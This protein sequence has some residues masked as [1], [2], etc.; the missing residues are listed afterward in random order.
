MSAFDAFFFGMVNGRGWLYRFGYFCQLALDK[1]LLGAILF[2]AFD[3]LQV[4]LQEVGA[5]VP[6]KS[7]SQRRILS[8][9][10]LV[11]AHDVQEYPRHCLQQF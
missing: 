9:F 4:R 8:I 10:A 3:A 1:A 7:F 2:G 6:T 11:I 5:F